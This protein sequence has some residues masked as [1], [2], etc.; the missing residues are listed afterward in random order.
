[1]FQ[2]R[3][4]SPDRPQPEAELWADQVATSGSNAR[5]PHGKD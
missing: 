1:M 2:G 4:K 5:Q 3:T